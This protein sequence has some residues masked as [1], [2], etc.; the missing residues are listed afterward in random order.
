MMRLTLLTAAMALLTSIAV[1]KDYVATI[2][3]VPNDGDD[4]T[5]YRVYS[6]PDGVKTLL[7][8]G[9]DTIFETPIVAPTVYSVAAYND[10]GESEVVPRVAMVPQVAPK[11]IEY[12]VIVQEM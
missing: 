2:T 4:V 3:W 9:T 10:F 12:R 6:Y 7:Y 11:I 8:E 1:A 5:G